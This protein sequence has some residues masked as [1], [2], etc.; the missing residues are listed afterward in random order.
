MIR[1]FL[2]DY[3][4][5]F[6]ERVKIVVNKKINKKQRQKEIQEDMDNIIHLMNEGYSRDDAAKKLGLDSSTVKQWY[7][8]GWHNEGGELYIN[9]FKDVRAIKY[10]SSSSKRKQ[11]KSTDVSSKKSNSRKNREEKVLSEFNEL[12]NSQKEY[13]DN[14]KRKVFKNKFTRTNYNYY[15]KLNMGRIIDDF[16]RKFIENEKTIVSNEFDSFFNSHNGFIDESV[17]Q[18][19]ENKYHKRYFNYYNYF[20]MDYVIDN[21]NEKF[22]DKEANT[23]LDEFNSFLSSQDA[24]IDESVK[25][26]LKNKYYKHYCNYYSRLNMGRLVDDYNVQ[27]IKNEKI[28]V[29]EEFNSF[30]SSQDG[31]IDEKTRK[32]LKTKFNKKYYDYYSEL[33][34]DNLIEEY[35]KEF[36]ENLKKEL[37]DKYI[38]N[39]EKLNLIKSLNYNFDISSIIEE[40]NKEYIEAQAELN[41]SYFENI[42]GKSLD[43]NQIIAVLTD[44]DNTQIVAGAGTGKTLTLQAKVKY[45]IEKQGVAPEDI[46]CISFSNSARDDLEEKLKRTVGDVGIDVRT[47]H[48]LG[49]NI[50]GINGYDKEVPNNEISELIENYFKQSISKNPNLIKDFVEFFCYY[51]NVIHINAE[52]LK[53]ETIKSRLNALNE[54]DE[55]LSEY[56]QVENVRKTREY[57]ANISEL[58]VANYLFIHHIPYKR[59]KQAVF[60]DKNYDSQVNFFANYLFDGLLECIPRNIQLESIK[61]F[62]EEFGDKLDLYPSFFLPEDDCYIELMPVNSDWEKSLAF[63]DKQKVKKQLD[64]FNSLNKKYETKLLAIF[65]HEDDIESLLENIEQQLSNNHIQI[66]NLDYEFLFKNLI[67][68]NELPEYNIFIKTVESFINLF[69][70]NAQ[71]IDSDGNDISKE[72]FNAFQNENSKKYN[73]SFKKRNKFYLNL[74]EEIYGLYTDNLIKNDYIDFNDMINDA[75][76]ELRN[77]AYIHNF[78]YVIVDEYQDTSHTRYKLLKEVQNVT[79]AKVVVVGDDW[80]SIYGFTGCDVHLFSQFENY[81]ENPKRITIDVTH[82]NSLQ[83]IKVIGNFIQENKKLIPKELKSDYVTQEFPIKIYEYT[84]RAYEVLALINILNEISKKKKDADILILGR[85]NKDIYEISCNEIFDMIQ[86]N[87][88][89]RIEYNNCPDLNIEF[90]TVHKS[91]GLEADYVVV[92]NLNN[93]IDG[94]PNKIVNDPILDFV[95]NKQS[96]DIDFAEE[97]RLFYVALTRTKNE[98]YLFYKTKRPSQFIIDIKDKK[99]V[100]YL[101]YTFS[102]NDVIYI[103]SLLQKRFEVIETENICPICKIGNVNLIIN[104]ER[105]TSYF[106]CSNFCGWNGAPY[107]NKSKDDGTR[108]ID[109]VKYAKVCKKCKGMLIVKRNGNDGSHFLGC[110]FYPSCDKSI[111]PIPGF[112]ELE[113]IELNIVD[114]LRGINSTHC[115]V[116]YMNDYV[117]EDKR[118]YYD[119]ELVDFSKRL[120]GFKSDKDEYSINL[121][122]QDLIKFIK[123]LSQNK[124]N[125]FSKLA[126]IAVP[127]SKVNKT[128]NSMKKSIDLIEKWYDNGDLKSDFDFDKEIINYKNLLKRVKDVPTAHKGEGRASCEEHIESIECMENQLSNDDIA[129]LILDDITTTGD[130]MKACN[131]I[132]LENGVNSKNIFNIAIGATVWDENEEI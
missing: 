37:D 44:D 71:N 100:Q 109:Y 34:L 99:G 70:G 62:D 42:D 16:N 96:E 4:L 48:S 47:F 113:D 84:S 58:I 130:T 13:I 88:Y 17:K 128:K 40:H 10:P 114:N 93:Q 125:N 35:N 76:I 69:K 102:N 82:R 30:L 115:G 95:N 61:E 29:L 78:K 65:D 77:G 50:L 126:L 75:I 120:I 117:P 15:S 116:Y 132:L 122:S 101:D 119:K 90:R 31:F 72:M 3:C 131:E 21:H 51:F 60:K 39:S 57:V 86:F 87:D 36:V 43:K 49:Y 98:V 123:L 73:N 27:F 104:N 59:L 105:G 45:L 83:L 64:E 46:L 41:K 112:K 52:N 11:N 79:G 8:K 94:F 20:K 80:Q 55:F 106:R 23:I 124:F 7:D 81:F 19:L 66:K 6:L 28:S 56:L 89:T 110:A 38:S 14:F 85:N 18:S 54:Y 68:N 92:L 9:F 107:H 118:L 5:N 2:S 24:F 108:K 26:S 32:Y 91:K 33:D 103:N 1:L 25:E 53:L 127:S 129:Y 67:L 97:R 63:K 22:I 121:F 74:I 111:S 12:L